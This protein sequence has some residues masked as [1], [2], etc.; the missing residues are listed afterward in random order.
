[1]SDQRALD[2]LKR[3]ER[4]LARIEA[5]ASRPAPAPQAAADSA[6]F[7]RLKQAHDRL[8]QRVAGAIGEIDR[9]IDSGGRR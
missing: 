1:M 3:L 2:A 9:L 7:E 5:A 6:E 8:R 4:A